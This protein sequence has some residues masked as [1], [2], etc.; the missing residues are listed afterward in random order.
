MPV[1]RQRRGALPL[2]D[3]T[4]F[5]AS[6]F[7]GMTSHSLKKKSKALI[8]MIT[9]YGGYLGLGQLARAY[10]SALPRVMPMAVASC[11]IALF[12]KFEQRNR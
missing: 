10:G 3:H 6:S 5:R 9:L 1:H 4:P 8:A 11:L 12:L 7:G 2:M